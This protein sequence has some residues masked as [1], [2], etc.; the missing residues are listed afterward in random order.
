MMRGEHKIRKTRRKISFSPR[1]RQ[2]HDKY[3]ACELT[4]KLRELFTVLD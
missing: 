4:D 2:Q 1:R 3:Y